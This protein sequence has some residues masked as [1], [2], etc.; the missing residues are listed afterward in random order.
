[1]KTVTLR[2]IPP[3]LARLLRRKAGEKRTSLN[4]TVIAILE[5][6]L[7]TDG[8][9]K[10]RPLHRDLDAL[11]GSWTREEA[12]SFDKTLAKQRRIDPDTWR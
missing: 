1:M 7:G 3:E 6:T 12:S 2:K 9:K 4:R 8:E 11:A 10:R 5:E